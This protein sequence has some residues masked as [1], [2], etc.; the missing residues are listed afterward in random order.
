[1]K[2]DIVT[3]FP[4]MFEGPFSE[5]IIGKAKEKKLVE[6][7]THDLREW[8]LGKYKQV[9][10]NP[11]GGGAGMVL[12]FEPIY[13]CLKDLNPKSEILNSKQGQNSEPKANKTKVKK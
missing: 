1:M 11:F 4:K 13:N 7:N 10:D 9:D 6:I 3:L 2:I 8:G 12:M 5:S